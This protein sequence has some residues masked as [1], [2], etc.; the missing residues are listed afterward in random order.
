MRKSGCQSLR[1]FCVKEGF[2]GWFENDSIS[3]G[4]EDFPP[5]LEGSPKPIRWS[6]RAFVVNVSI[7]FNIEIHQQELS[8]EA[9]R[10]QQRS[11]RHIFDENALDRNSTHFIFQWP[12]LNCVSLFL[13]S[14][15]HWI[16]FGSCHISSL[17]FSP[18]LPFSYSISSHLFSALCHFNLF[19]SPLSSSFLISRSP[20]GSSG[21]PLWSCSVPIFS[22]HPFIVQFSLLLQPSAGPPCRSYSPETLSLM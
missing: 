20:L 1:V 13:H 12:I 9:I 8:R 16:C 22:F 4:R 19:F 18:Y 6:S 5:V 15:P 3:S 2:E 7:W 14:H 10:W 21:S 17:P 11:R